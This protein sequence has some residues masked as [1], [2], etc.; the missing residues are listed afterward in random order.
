MEAHIP[1]LRLVNTDAAKVELDQLERQLGDRLRDQLLKAYG[2]TIRRV[3]I[4][5]LTVPSETLVATAARMRAE[6]QT[7]AAERMAVGGR[8]AAE[9]RSNADRD[10][11]VTIARAHAE[12]A[13]AEAKSRVRA[14]DI[15]AQTYS[16]NP[17][18]YTLLR[19]FETLDSVIGQNTRM[20]LRTDAVPFSRLR[21][22]SRRARIAG[23][24]GRGPTP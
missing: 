19:S 20:I 16:S 10:A 22:R 23:Q 11:R 5:S 18:H 9:I 2:I 13:A 14:A 21:R 1:S 15:Y 3:G 6:L 4:K 8:V 7:I 12:A 17:G 24:S